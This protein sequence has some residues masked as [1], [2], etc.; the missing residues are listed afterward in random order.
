MVT[1]TRAGQATHPPVDQLL[2]RVTN[3]SSHPQGVLGWCFSLIFVCSFLCERVPIYIPGWPGTFCVILRSLKL[4]LS[5]LL[6]VDR[7]DHHTWPHPLNKWKIQILLTSDGCVH[8][9][10]PW[11]VFTTSIPERRDLRGQ[12]DV[13]CLYCCACA[14]LRIFLSHHSCKY[15]N[16]QTVL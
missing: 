1:L 9:E 11:V 14:F 12:P 7:C 3:Y 10:Y 16:D 15:Q 6:S 5:F 4:M 13:C 2:L 8:D